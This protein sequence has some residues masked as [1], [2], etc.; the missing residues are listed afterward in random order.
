MSAITETRTMTQVHCDDCKARGE[1]NEFG[2]M[3]GWAVTRSGS[4]PQL[5]RGDL[6]GG[7]VRPVVELDPPQ[8]GDLWTQVVLDEPLKTVGPSRAVTGRGFSRAGEKVGE[9]VERGQ[10]LPSRGRYVYPWHHGRRVRR[11]Q[12]RPVPL[13]VCVA[14]APDF[15]LLGTQFLN[16]GHDDG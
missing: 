15:E 12:R 7:L 3:W 2:A 5:M 4:Q 1:D 14:V 11:K 16:G 6:L 8:C 13:R 10:P 9:L